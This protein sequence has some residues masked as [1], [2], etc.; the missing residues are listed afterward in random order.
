[1]AAAQRELAALL[2]YRLDQPA[3]MLAQLVAAELP[4]LKLVIWSCWYQTASSDKAEI[5]LV[6]V[7]AP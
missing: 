3:M 6:K 1:L 7:G 2:R 5:N 4:V